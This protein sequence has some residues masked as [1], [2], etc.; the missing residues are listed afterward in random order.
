[1]CA[2]IFTSRILGHDSYHR[3]CNS[4]TSQGT[5]LLDLPLCRL[6]SLGL[7]LRRLIDWPH[8]WSRMCSCHYLLLG[9]ITA[10]GNGRRIPQ[11]TCLLLLQPWKVRGTPHEL[12]PLI[13]PSGVLPRWSGGVDATHYHELS[14]SI[15]FPVGTESNHN[16]AEASLQDCGRLETNTLS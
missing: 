15:H 13:P 14:D 3:R 9:E 2:T 1:M 11:E 4:A 6:S 16:E 7:I 5:G 10:K 12:P 8:R